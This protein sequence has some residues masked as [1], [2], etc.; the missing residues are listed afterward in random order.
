VTGRRLAAWA[1]LAAAVAAVWLAGRPRGGI[2]TGT[3]IDWS[4]EPLQEPTGRAPFE[5]E[6]RKG[7]LTL[8]PRAAYDVAARVEGAERYRFDD[9]AF[10]SPLDLLLTWG[11]L[12]TP[13]YRDAL[14]Y[15]QSWRFFF[16]RTADLAL[17]P[18]YVVAHS[19][20][21]H[22]IPADEGI[23]R[24]LLSIDPGDDVR[25][26]GLLVDVRGEAFRWPTSTVRTDHGDGGCEILWVESVEVDG[27]RYQSA[28]ATVGRAP[29]TG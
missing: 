12:P 18:D 29:G 27:R 15:S 26:T 11:E 4:R 3:T 16:W 10:L 19:A 21:T 9:L 23:E 25:L 13:R 8:V 6:T 24:A 1:I 20:N 17:D 7:T 28:A 5:L 22:L 14:D 2:A